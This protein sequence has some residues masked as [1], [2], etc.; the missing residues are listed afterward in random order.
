VVLRLIKPYSAYQRQVNE[1]LLDAL[2]RSRRTEVELAHARARFLAERRAVQRA[3]EP[4]LQPTPVPEQ[5]PDRASTNG[6]QPL[7]ARVDSVESWWHSID[8][9]HG[10][11]TPGEKGDVEM[12][13]DELRGLRL[14][15]LRG[16]TVLDIGAWDGFYSF[17]AERAGAERVVALDHFVW[18]RSPGRRGF[19]LAH[20][21]LDSRVEP[22]EADFMTLDTDALGTF[23]VVLFLGVLYHLQDPLG[24]LRRLAAVTDGLAVI[25]S[26]ALVIPGHEELAACEFYA[27]DE[28]AGDNTNWWGPTLPAIHQL[29]AAAGFDRTETVAGPPAVSAALAHPVHYRAVVHAWMSR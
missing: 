15:D 1:Q 17:E 18:E 25:E 22:V 14:P 2:H 11:V 23:E 7:Q 19:D 10:V 4:V 8:L 13:A 3:A 24:A 9:G 6:S 27:G 12:M 29:C 5:P 20:A 21:A 28:L 16:K 26:E